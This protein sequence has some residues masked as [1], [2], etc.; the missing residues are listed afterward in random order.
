MVIKRRLIIWLIKAYIQ[1]WGKIIVLYFF[2]GLAAFF[3]LLFAFSY[4]APKLPLAKREVIGAVG[5]YTVDSIPDYILENVSGGLSNVGVDG[6]AK[7]DLASS[8]GIE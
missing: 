7:P 3:L 2:L 6:V 1:R 4:I 5:A 8:W